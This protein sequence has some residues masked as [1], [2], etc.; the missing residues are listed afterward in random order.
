MLTRSRDERL[1]H[2]IHVA[3]VS[4]PHRQAKTHSPVAISPVRYRRINEFLVW[5]DHGDIVVS[6]NDGAARA[7]L[8]HLTGDAR[9][10]NAISDGDWPFSKNEQAADE[11]TR[12]VFQTEPNAYA[13]RAGEYRQRA[14]VDTG[15]VENDDDPDD[16]HDVTDDLRNG[17]LERTIQSA[18]SKESVKKKALRSRGDP[19]NGNQERDKQKNLKET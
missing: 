3:P 14:E 5:N 11:I 13:D 17:V 9:D 18:L 12:D 8:L 4:Y 2:F 16:Q 10:F 1:T 15:I 19:K 7:D 6:K